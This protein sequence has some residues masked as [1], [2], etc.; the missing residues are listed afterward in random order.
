MR[1]NGVI[2]SCL[3]IFSPRNCSSRFGACSPGHHQPRYWVWRSLRAS[4]H[5]PQQ[6]W[7]GPE[8][9]ATPSGVYIIEMFIIRI[10][11]LLSPKPE[12]NSPPQLIHGHGIVKRVSA[13]IICAVCV[14]KFSWWTVA[15]WCCEGKDPLGVLLRGGPPGCAVKGMTPWVCC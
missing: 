7:A 5:Y 8:C 3:M 4:V 14:S 2:L 1:V 13:C 6:A 10:R 12:L 15:G 9:A 11:H